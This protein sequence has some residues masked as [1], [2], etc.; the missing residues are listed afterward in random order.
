MVPGVD[1]PE[2]G[3]ERRPLHTAFVAVGL[4]VTVGF[5]YLA[6]RNVQLDEVWDALESSEWWWLAP[7]A[8]LLAVTVVLR[9]ARWQSLFAPETRPSLREVLAALL[10]GYLFN[11]LLPLRAGEAARVLALKRRAGSS[12][13]EAG[14]TVVVERAYDILALLVLL[15]LAAPLLPEVSWLGAAAILGAVVAAGIAVAIVVVA[16]YGERPL[17][18]MLRPLR[19]IAPVSE[20]RLERVAV[21]AVGGL[22]GLRSPRI[23]LAAFAWTMLSWVALA[24]SC[25]AL[26]AGFDTGLSTEDLVLAGL[27]VVIATNLALVLPSSPAAIGVFEAATLV[28]LGA[29]GISDSLA[30]SY[31]L[32]LHAL[33]LVPY[34]VVGALVLR[35]YR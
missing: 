33:N 7:S 24:G 11:N 3:V 13:A 34:L 6:V 29:Y 4:A 17:L 10:V 22:A 9:A 16:L 2:L 30:L 26:L 18:A 12:R 8:A 14:A 32:V 19:R 31:A 5:G 25:A 23:A 35:R 1:P 20:E 27:L 28:A 15:F 21:S